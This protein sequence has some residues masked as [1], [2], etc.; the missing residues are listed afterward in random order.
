MRTYQKI[1][2]DHKPETKPVLDGLI[3]VEEKVDGSQFRIEIDDQGKISCASHHQELNLLDSPFKK[4]TD[5]AQNI[6]KT[7][8]AKPGDVVSVFC[9]YLEKPKHNAIPYARVPKDNL[10]IWDVFENGRWLYRGDKE[11]F[12]RSFGME[13]VPLLWAG[14]AQDFTKE[15][16]AELLSRESFL[17]HQGGYDRIEGIVV[18]NYDKFWDPEK[19]SWLTGHYLALKIVNDSFKEKNRVANPTRGNGLEELK[20]SCRTEA[21]WRKAVQHLTEKGLLVNDMKDLSSICPRVIQDL[22]EEEKETI[23]EELWKL[24]KKDILGFS[25]KGLPEWYL[26]H[27]RSLK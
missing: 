18:K 22:E 9:E 27:L 21:R 10:V 7:F 4:A 1:L 11:F 25:V 17:K 23:K 16:Q 19:Y 13:V 20:E 15:L 12:A 2:G 26:E 3:V 5:T 24:Y 8:R 6:F 14:V